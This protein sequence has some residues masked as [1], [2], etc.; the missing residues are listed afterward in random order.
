MV[1]FDYLKKTI[2]EEDE[3]IKYQFFNCTTSSF[4]APEGPTKVLVEWKLGDPLF[5]TTKIASSDSPLFEYLARTDFWIT[6]GNAHTCF[7]HY[8][9]LS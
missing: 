8:L 4:V 2:S 7:T 5:N 1:L 9:C 3:L 6:L